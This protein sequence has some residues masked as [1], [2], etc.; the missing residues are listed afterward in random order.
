LRTALAAL[1]YNSHTPRDLGKW[2]EATDH[3]GA[4]KDVSSGRKKAFE[5]LTDHLV[6]KTN[7]S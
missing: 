4:A 6:R 2:L 5:L 7:S 1:L 3:E